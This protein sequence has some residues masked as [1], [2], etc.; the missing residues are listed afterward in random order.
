M[1]YI[2]CPHCLHKYGVNER[3]RAAVGKKIHCKLCKQ[4]FRIVV[5]GVP[6][7]PSLN[8]NTIETSDEKSTNRKS[9]LPAPKPKSPELTTTTDQRS[10]TAAGDED[11][12]PAPIKL[13]KRLNIQ[14]IVLLLLLFTL[15]CAVIGLFIYIQFPQWLTPK[16]EQANSMGPLTVIKPIKLF[17]AGP[18]QPDSTAK[19]T[20]PD[21]VDEMAGHDKTMLEGPDKPSQVCRDSAADF[22]IRIHIMSTSK[23]DSRTYMQLMNQGLGQPAEI[24]NLCRDRFLTGRLTEAAKKDQ[25]P[26]WISAEVNAR[27]KAR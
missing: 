14:F 10:F 2:Q 19:Q 5:L 1:E 24:R 26:D 15:S 23:I 6:D 22:W 27:T 9:L 11:E 18:P 3:M 16:A 8:T 25:L 17:P 4:L 7:K 20:A 13:K 12:K 21:P